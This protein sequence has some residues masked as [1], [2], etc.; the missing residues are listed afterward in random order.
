MTTQ[1]VPYGTGSRA[2]AIFT[3]PT[4]PPPSL[5]TSGTVDC[6]ETDTPPVGLEALLTLNVPVQHEAGD[7]L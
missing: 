7:S 2:P 1:G 4:V 3:D 5:L 6:L